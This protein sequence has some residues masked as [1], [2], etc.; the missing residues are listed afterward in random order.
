[1]TLFSRINCLLINSSCVP[2]QSES[3]YSRIKNNVVREKPQKLDAATKVTSAV[4]TQKCAVLV[5]SALQQ[6]FGSVGA[7]V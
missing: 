4:L 7:A 3:L 1:M 6:T 2:H 5:Q